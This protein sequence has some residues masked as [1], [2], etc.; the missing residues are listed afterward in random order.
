M[1]M[2]RW[3]SKH[4][5]DIWNNSKEDSLFLMSVF[6]ELLS[7][8]T[9]NQVLSP[10]T[11]CFKNSRNCRENGPFQPDPSCSSSKNL[12]DNKWTFID[13]LSQNLERFQYC[14]QNVERGTQLEMVL[15]WRMELLV[16]DWIFWQVPGEKSSNER[17]KS[18]HK[19]RRSSVRTQVTHGKK[20]RS[21]D[22]FLTR[23]NKNLEEKKVII[24]GVTE[25][26]LKN[27]FIMYILSCIKYP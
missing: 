8:D 5:K 24:K 14:P 12:R 23:M 21:N 22:F 17:E 10:T 9:W 13:I 7:G 26:F 27:N 4:S 20:R 1:V 19:I 15:R 6:R 3:F 25:N 2:L 16:N 18:Y 11:P